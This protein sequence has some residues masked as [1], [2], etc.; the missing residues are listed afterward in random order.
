VCSNTISNYLIAGRELP[1]T[2]TDDERYL[3]RCFALAEQGRYTCRPNPVVGCV[4]VFDGSVVAEGWHQT[5][6]QAHAE[7]LAL[8]QAGELTVGSTV[9]VSLEPCAHQGRTGPC[10][11][12]LIQ[13]GI[14]RL[15]YGMQD[16]N[17]LVAGRGLARLREVGITVDGPL[18]QAEAAALN[19]GFIKRMTQGLPYVRCKVGMSLDARTA[20]HSGESQ[21]ITGAAARTEVQ[22]L[23]ARSCA[24]LTGI[25]TLLQDDPALTVRLESYQGLQP[26]RVIA[27]THG[28]TSVRAKTLHVPGQV[29]LAA[30][31]QA[32]RWLQE[33][34]LFSSDVQAQCT[35]AAVPLLNGK[36]NLPALL[37]LVATDWHCNEVLVEAGSEL[38]GALLQAGLVDELITYI[39]PALLGDTARPLAVLPGLDR[40]ADKLSLQFLDVAMV[41]EDC[42]IRSRVLNP[43]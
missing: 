14:T 26:L 18:L 2:M 7:V 35:I 4:V 42:R 16:P 36:L 10:T 12:A 27:D 33:Q 23:R 31:P 29:L 5:A 30:S 13:S 41:G 6:G 21:W 34:E 38:T 37:R 1:N 11:E 28:R 8:E 40:L 24:L 32:A 39:A 20:M 9:Y 3:R 15:V 17:P 19:P 43:P 25:G 22:W